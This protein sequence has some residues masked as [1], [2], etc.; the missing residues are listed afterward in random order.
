LARHA[1]PG[2]DRRILNRINSLFAHAIKEGYAANLGAGYHG[3]YYKVLKGQGPAAP[4]GETDDVIK[5]R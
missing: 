4:L 1:R 2:P 3:D 5:G